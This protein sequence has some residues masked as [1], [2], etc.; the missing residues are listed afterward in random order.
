MPLQLESLVDCDN[1]DCGAVFEHAFIFPEYVETRE[2]ID[3]APREK[4]MCPAC[5]HSQEAEWG[6]WTAHDEA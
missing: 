5:H 1:P 3:E 6:G 2:D 4:V